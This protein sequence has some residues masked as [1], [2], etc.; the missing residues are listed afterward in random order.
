MQELQ[1][2]QASGGSGGSGAW[3]ASHPDS[4][5][6]SNA[7]D[8]RTSQRT[9]QIRGPQGLHFS[10]VLAMNTPYIKGEKWR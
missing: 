8:G 10:N 4:V 1:D 3:E 2:T 6:R 5:A 9:I 7:M